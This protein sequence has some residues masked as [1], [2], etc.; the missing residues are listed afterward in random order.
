MVTNAVRDGSSR[1]TQYF[2]NLIFYGKTAFLFPV[3]IK[4][5]KIHYRLKHIILMIRMF[6]HDSKQIDEFEFLEFGEF[7]FVFENKQIIAFVMHI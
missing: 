3:V 5:F 1:F 4:I 6:N 7:F 2:P